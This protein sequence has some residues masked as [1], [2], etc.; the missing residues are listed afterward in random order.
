MRL[1]W[2]RRQCHNLPAGAGSLV[3]LLPQRLNQRLEIAA[4]LG[5]HFFADAM[6]FLDDGV[7][8]HGCSSRSWVGV[9]MTGGSKPLSRHANSIFPRSVAFAKWRQFH[10]NR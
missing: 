5:Q 1:G 8:A 6:Y 2:A 4:M 3:G 10:V 7:F 9:Q